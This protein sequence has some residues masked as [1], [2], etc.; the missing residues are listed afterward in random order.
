MKKNQVL[1]LLINNNW[2][3]E[4]VYH[5]SKLS[6]DHILKL[7]SHRWDANNTQKNNTQRYNA[8]GKNE[9]ET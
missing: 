8:Y 7:K 9:K 4:R 2:A 5:I 6:E 3:L 1:S